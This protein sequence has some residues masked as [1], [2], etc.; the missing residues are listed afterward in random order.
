M[1][2]PPAN[3]L[4]LP[5]LERA[6]LALEAAVKKVIEEHA[7]KGRPLYIWRDGEVVAVSAEEF[8]PRP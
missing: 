7:R 2:K 4:A 3:V 6:T 8:L 1:N 5:L